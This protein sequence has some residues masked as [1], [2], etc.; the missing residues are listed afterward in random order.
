MKD[1]PAVVYECEICGAL[2]AWEWDGDC[3]EDRARLQPDEIPA[4]TE[5]RSMSE[6]V[7]AD[8][9]EPMKGNDEKRQIRPRP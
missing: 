1:Y 4:T 6:R 8:H 3:R 7:A 9:A 5:I 2:H